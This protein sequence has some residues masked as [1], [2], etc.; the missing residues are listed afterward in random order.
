[1]KHWVVV[2]GL[3]LGWA[4]ACGGR[5]ERFI[6][7]GD[8]GSDGVGGSTGGSSS[9]G[10]PSVG[11]GTTTGGSG[12]GVGGSSVGGGPSVG[13]AAG[14]G[15]FGGSINP[16]GFGGSVIGGSGG[17]VIAGT[18]GSA[19]QGGSAG[20]GGLGGGGAGGTAGKGGTAGSAGA[21]PDACLECTSLNCPDA[22]TCLGNPACVQ[23]TLCGVTQCGG[24][25]GSGALTC[26]IEC[27]NGDTAL[28]LSALSA[29][30]CVSGACA[31]ACA[32]I[33]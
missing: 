32:G 15:A 12:P 25:E 31:D 23:G 2:F 27:Y 16:G 1:M 13:G 9:G 4:S 26:W 22:F 10:G 33:L 28:A 17:S 29:V 11:G 21:S 5:S 20:K 8:G 18:G 7:E 14:V 6:G 3:S 19:G 24:L 30:L